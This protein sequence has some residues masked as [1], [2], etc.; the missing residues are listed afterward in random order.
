MQLSVRHK[1]EITLYG[2][3]P[4]KQ[5]TFLWSDALRTGHETI[6]RQ[7]KNIEVSAKREHNHYISSVNTDPTQTNDWIYYSS[8][9]V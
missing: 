7:H 2:P 1:P 9:W 4:T 8:P 5:D 6:D 3:D